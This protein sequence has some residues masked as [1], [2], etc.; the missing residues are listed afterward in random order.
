MLN[1]NISAAIA[2]KIKK[3]DE[4]FSLFDGRKKILAA[5]SGGADSCCLLLCLCELGK[6][7]GFSVGAIHVNHGIRGAEADRDENFAKSLC[8]RLNI[9]FYCERAD[10]PLLSKKLGISEELCA[11]NVRYKL[12]EE[13]CE[14]HGFDCVAVAHNACDNAETVLFNLARGAALKGMCGIPAKRA[15]GT[16]GAVI[17][18]PLIYVSRNEIEDFLTEL[19]QSFVTDS[20]NLSDD[21]TRNYIR[22]VI[23][24]S[25]G[26]INSSFEHA[27]SRTV[28]L[29]KKD[30]DY[31]EKIAAENDTDRLELLS[32][33]DE[34]ILSR[35][36]RNRFR[37]ISSQMPEEK[38]V[39]ALCD[40]IYSFS[41]NQLLKCSISFP[42]R[43]KA[44]IENAVLSF[45]E[46]D[47]S[48]EIPKSYNIS[49]S[50]GINIIDGTDF[51]YLIVYKADFKIPEAITHNN[52]IIY[53]K[54]TTDYL[55][56][57]KIHD[58]LYARNR[59]PGDVIFCGNQ[60][61]SV[62][63][64]MCEKKIPENERHV[65]PMLCLGED[66]VL[67]PKTARSDTIKKRAEKVCVTAVL[68]R[69]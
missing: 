25:F 20:T 63:R 21:Y 31:L 2:A 45:C 30:S 68:Y 41:K 24:P 14:K 22:H 42:D 5:L 67:I 50:E 8:E 56:F 17:I 4:E 54:Y 33:L 28:G 26:K 10:V 48:K 64:L 36:I 62:K 37:R 1:L 6:K 57:D 3:A 58:V 19:G 53:K 69:L 27:V 61:K 65:I 9:P 40:K 29:L 44:V 12:F 35:I 34:C 11:R 39:S 59:K 60:R 18:R 52:E 15:L 38:H 49:L 13:Y 66:V 43:K 23:I 46:D 16:E 55:Y 47:R 7:Y 51:A 32:T